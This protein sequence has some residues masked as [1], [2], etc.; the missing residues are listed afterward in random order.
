MISDPNLPLLEEAAFKLS[1]LL[2]EIVFVGGAI[3]GLLIVDPGAAPIRG[4]TDVDVIA[5]IATYTEYVIFS[6]RLRKQHFTEDMSEDTIAC[7]WH[8]KGKR[9]R[10]TPVGSGAIVMDSGHERRDR[11]GGSSSWSSGD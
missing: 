6:E 5:E 10:N 2:D 9:A 3:L 1:P 11:S 8:N 7:R 4:T